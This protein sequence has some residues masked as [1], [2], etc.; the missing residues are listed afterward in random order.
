MLTVQEQTEIIQKVRGALNQ[1]EAKLS[2]INQKASTIP[3]HKA[4][5]QY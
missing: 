4:N 1:Y 2:E 5:G 3:P